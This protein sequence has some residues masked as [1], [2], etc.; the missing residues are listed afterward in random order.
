MYDSLNSNYLIVTNLFHDQL[1]RYGEINFTAQKIQSAIDK[2]K[3]L[4][5]LL[6]ADDPLVVNLKPHKNKNA[7]Y[8]GI[9]KIEYVSGGYTVS[10]KEI[11]NCPKCGKELEY[12]NIFYGHQGHYSCSCGY[13]RPECKYS[14]DIIV[15]SDYYSIKFY[16]E[17]KVHEF[18]TSLV[19]LYNVYNAIGAIAM[20]FE[21]GITDIQKALDSY[22]PEFGRSEI[23]EIF[24]KRAI[25]QLIKN[26][27]GANEVLKTVDKTSSI[28]I[29]INDNYADG[30]DMSWLWDTDFEILNGCTNPIVTSGI[31]AYDVATRLKYAG[32]KDIKI[33][34]N[35][36]DAIKEVAKGDKITI[37]PSY[38]VLL[39]INKNKY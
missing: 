8:Y 25:I 7:I 27:T 20:C 34:P 17:E 22:H 11:L 19:G 1:D 30:R 5:V 29:A 28:L 31:R 6:N 15:H 26:P 4:K 3:D 35:L 36:E 16:V 12:S 2:N 38:T 18:S 9:N 33:I 13:C 37:L 32:I 14:A 39:D 23:R 21:L 10:K 24:G